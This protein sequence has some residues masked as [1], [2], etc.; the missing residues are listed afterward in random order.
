MSKLDKTVKAIEKGVKVIESVEKHLSKNRG[1]P[2][3]RKDHITPKNPPK[4]HEQRNHAKSTRASG[5]RIEY[6]DG[7]IEPP[8]TKEIMTAWDR[9]TMAK[10]SP[11]NSNPQYVAGMNV[12][13]VPT[14]T[15]SVTNT[16]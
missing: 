6:R 1:A 5:R 9:M 16:L 2:N 4:S 15:F 8:R 10:L 13:Q 11:G 12:T 7:I 14:M 3:L